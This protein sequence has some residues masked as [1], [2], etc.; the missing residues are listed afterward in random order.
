[1]NSISRAGANFR[2]PISNR[3]AF[4]ELQ[5]ALRLARVVLVSAH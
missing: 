1:M 3:E 5:F 4:E 2:I